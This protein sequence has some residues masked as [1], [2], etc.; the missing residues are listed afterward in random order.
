M[1]GQTWVG[2]PFRSDGAATLASV[3]LLLAN[4]VSGTAELGLYQGTTQPATLIGRLTSP[5]SYSAQLSYTLFT[6]NNLA[7]TGA[8][9]YWLV[10]YP[11]S[12][13]FAWAFTDSNTG[14]GVGFI[15][16]WGVTDDAG[17]TWF[18]QASEPM[19]MRVEVDAAQ[20]VPEPASVALLL[21]GMA[22]AASVAA[23]GR[24]RRKRAPYERYLLMFGGAFTLLLL[25]VGTAEAAPSPVSVVSPAYGESVKTP[26]A[27]SVTVQID[28]AMVGMP[29]QVTLNGMDVS[30]QFKR[31]GHCGA[32]G[33]PYHGT[34]IELD[35]LRTDMNRLRVGLN[36]ATGVLKPWRTVFAWA[37]SGQLGSE[38][39]PYNSPAIGFTTATPGGDYPWISIFN[40]A[41]SGTT[42]TYPSSKTE[43]CTTAYQVLALKR[44]TLE[45]SSY[46]CYN[47]DAD[48]TAALKKLPGQI[49]IAGT[50][51]SKNALPNLDTTP[52]G[53]TN[54]ANTAA[55][56]Y[57]YGYIVV[58]VQGAP[59]GQAYENASTLESGHN[60][61]SNFARANGVL[62]IN[63]NNMYDFHSSD[64]VEFSVRPSDSTIP[65]KSASISTGEIKY[66]PPTGM[67]GFWLLLLDRR[68]LYSQTPCNN[69]T[70]PLLYENCGTFYNTGNIDLSIAITEQIKLA[71]AL[72]GAGKS[73]L[74]FLL[75]VGTPI[76]SLGDAIVYSPLA[77]AID[78]LGA[79]GYTLGRV[80]SISSPIY[81]LVSSND[82]G[83]QKTFTDS[84]VVSNNVDQI[85][86]LSG[87]QQTGFVHGVMGRDN[88]G[89]FRPVASSQ[90]SQTTIDT[91]DMRD[92]SG[93]SL[94]WAP[95]VTW[96]YMDTQGSV[97][98]YRYL[99]YQLVTESI[100]NAQ[101]NYLDDVRFYYSGSLLDAVL[102]GN[103]G[104]VPCPSDG[105]TLAFTNPLDSNKIYTINH[106]AC[107]AV[108][109]QLTK[110]FKDLNS[111]VSFFDGASTGGGIRGAFFAASSGILANMFSAVSA[112]SNS[113]A[114]A[115]A[116][117]AKADANTAKWVKLTGSVISA[118]GEADPV[119]SV[120]S[121][122]LSTVASSITPPGVNG[123]N[124][125]SAFAQYESTVSNIYTQENQF[126][127]SLSTGFDIVIDN[128]Y[129]DWGKLSALSAKTG[130]TNSGGWYFPN[131]TDLVTVTG[132]IANSTKRYFYLQSLV[133]AYSVDYWPQLSV[134]LPSQI[135]AKVYRNSPI[136]SC[137]TVYTNL[138]KYS[139][140]SYP[141]PGNTGHND[142]FI[143]G[144]TIHSNQTSFAREDFPSKD[145]LTTLFE[146]PLFLQQ[147]LFFALHGPLPR[148]NGALPALPP[149][150]N[151]NAK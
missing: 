124:L 13:Q 85:P 44:Q 101:G 132:N 83:F 15:P 87:N 41:G 27:V 46:N 34:L 141:T 58:G 116:A 67:N 78:N 135:G 130:N 3:T 126:V 7:L 136:L 6:G 52:I 151:A 51:Y 2:A 142:I 99:S 134:Q 54:Y 96:P 76:I 90:E 17:L 25:G 97:E 74:I 22:L 91:P 53:G 40:N 62:T 37:P 61:P 100:G 75:S 70:N 92:F 102:H 56:D 110:E 1:Q 147:D 125:A 104:T 128:S 108:Q 146:G 57:P 144:G 111:S 35:G 145:L 42:T 68:N 71:E 19:K 36:D 123:A 23:A 31:S 63:P 149:V 4:S 66:T 120:M 86:G 113:T 21:A 50:S 112:V 122:I 88:H 139:W 39:Y 49:V 26:S 77:S 8:T 9:P 98:A 33:C 150:C 59:P 127:T 115:G 30:A 119:A 48:L 133:A 65:T 89:L 12:G 73:Q 107:T 94:F 140:F 43:A 93:Y 80:P 129:S 14:S 60:D 24:F 121:G 81:T 45:F 118:A 138:P 38:L 143:M 18:T 148:R 103:P 106:E 72:S 5:T 64:Y 69:P 16:S 131:N 84:A 11:V 137:E 47:T 10:L 105:N 32:Q 79:S 95:P 109:S 20:A 82:T 117:E 29:L 55:A 114:I 28:P